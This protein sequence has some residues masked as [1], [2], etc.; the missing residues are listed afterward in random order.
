MK[1]GLM[2]CQNHTDLLLEYS[3]R[4]LDPE[5]A[6]MLERHLEACRECAAVR[7]S[8]R[9]VWKA[10]DAWEVPAVSSSFNRNLYARIE[11]A[12]AMPWYLRW[13]DALRPVF[14]QPAFPLSIAAI[15]V[16]AGFVL[17]HSNPLPARPVAHAH[18]V[19][20][21]SATE[22]EQMERT[23]DDLEML[24]QFDVNTDQ[25]AEEK[26]NTLKSM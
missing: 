23:L 4:K 2:T 16:V 5:S 21:V 6:R 1:N 3:A 9:Q 7:D 10:L 8:H 17:D 22:A 11:A 25:K 18:P 20:K 15:V 13:L 24:H 12:D 19:I 26:E 14:T